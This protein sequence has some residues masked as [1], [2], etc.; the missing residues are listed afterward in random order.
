MHSLRLLQ[1]IVPIILVEQ[2]R[3]SRSSRTFAIVPMDRRFAGREDRTAKGCAQQQHE[4]V[5]MPHYSQLQSDMPQ[6]LEPSIGHCG[7]QEG[8][9]FLI[10]FRT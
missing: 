1:H 9:G 10:E 6:G 2:R 4:P 7:D 8:H 3:I 5:P